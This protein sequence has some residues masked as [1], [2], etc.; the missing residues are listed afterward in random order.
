MMI[1]YSHTSPATADS[2]ARAKHVIRQEAIRVRESAAAAAAVVFVSTEDG[3]YAYLDQ[4]EAD[5]DET[6]ILA[7]A[8][9]DSEFVL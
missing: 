2:I 4:D 5:A 9:I 8:T 6:G 1:R 3:I 7:F